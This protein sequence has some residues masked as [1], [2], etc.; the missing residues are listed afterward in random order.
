M[1]NT[2]V[3]SEESTPQRRL[4]WPALGTA[5][6]LIL[7]AVFPDMAWRSAE[8]VLHSLLLM[9]PI[10]AMAVVL[11][12]WIRASGAASLMARV[13][14]GRPVTMLLVAASFGTVTPICGIGVVPIIAGLLRAGVPLAPIMAFWLSS[15]ITSPPMLVVT[16]GL[17]GVEFAVAKT[18]IAFA[19]G[20]FGGAVTLYAQGHG[21]FQAPLRPVVGWSP[22]VC[23]STRGPDS[24]R[25]AFWHE[26]DRRRLFRT[27]ALGTAIMMV[28]WLTIAFALESIL[29]ALLPPETI[30]G[31][32]GAGTAW[33]IPLA[34]TIG[35]P[36]YLDGYAA[37][38]LVRGLI[39]LGMTPGAAMAF[40]VAGGITSAYASVAVFAL[41]RWPVFLWYLALAIVGSAAGGYGYEALVALL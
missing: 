6:L 39:D 14:D 38:P 7:A 21:A 18:V 15:P 2:P 23:E 5:A 3:T 20:I 13:F 28:K 29:V 30:V 32:V 33:A 4:V 36:I 25:W 10:V 27:E 24:L 31:Y 19:I 11:S 16:A 8:F 35:T 12:A 34:V 1:A 26:P 9:V 40:L 17:L 37:L 22:E 41:V